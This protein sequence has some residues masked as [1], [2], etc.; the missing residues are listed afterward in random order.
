MKSESLT[1]SSQI[2]YLEYVIQ[3]WWMTIPHVNW[4]LLHLHCALTTY[5][6]TSEFTFY[7]SSCCR[8]N[9]FRVLHC[10]EYLLHYLKHD[11][12]YTE[13]YRLYYILKSWRLYTTL[14]NSLIQAAKSYAGVK[15]RKIS[16]CFSSLLLT[17]AKGNTCFLEYD[18][19]F[20]HELCCF[21]FQHTIAMYTVL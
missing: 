3:S 17:I 4:H 10:L 21:L 20:R 18:Y 16:S 7:S 5:H 9:L 1:P 8:L 15:K 2:M 19:P 14:Q 13:L 6:P 12:G 11:W